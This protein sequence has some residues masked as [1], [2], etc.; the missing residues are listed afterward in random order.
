METSRGIT[1]KFNDSYTDGSFTVSDFVCLCFQRQSF[2]TFIVRTRPCKSLG[3]SSPNTRKQIFRDILIFFFIRKNVCCVY[4]SES[5]FSRIHSTYH[6][7]THDI[8]RM[9]GYIVFAFAFVRSFVRTYVCSFVFPSHRVKVFALKY[10]RPHI[11]KTLW[12]ISFIFSLIIDIGLKFL[13][14]PFPPQGWPWGQGHGLVIKKSNCFVF[15][16]I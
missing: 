11:L 6:Y 7:Y 12:W 5:F 15:T 10:I 4:S 13:S 16:F 1:V 9:W 8:R 14:A 3:N 2:L